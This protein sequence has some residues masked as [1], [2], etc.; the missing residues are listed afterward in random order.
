[1]LAFTPAYICP[2]W[3][4]QCID[5]LSTAVEDLYFYLIASRDVV[6]LVLTFG[7]PLAHMVRRGGQACVTR[8][9]RNEYKSC[10]S[11]RRPP[12]SEDLYGVPMYRFPRLQHLH[13]S[14]LNSTKQ[15]P[16]DS[17]WLGASRSSSGYTSSS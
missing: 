7:R 17:Q 16:C 13:K 3:D 11:P 10:S 12:V 15:T 9:S 1:M 4:D 8:S 14:Q 5:K 2:A 6:F